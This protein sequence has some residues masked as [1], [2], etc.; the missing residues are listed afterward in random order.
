MDVFNALIR[1]TDNNVYSPFVFM[2]IS[3]EDQQFLVNNTKAFIPEQVPATFNEWRI[4]KASYGGYYVHRATWEQTWYCYTISGI[5]AKL[6][7]YYN[8]R[9]DIK[10]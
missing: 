8:S 10:E 6:L 4:R 9:Q 2:G 7:E 5:L 3:E 1:T